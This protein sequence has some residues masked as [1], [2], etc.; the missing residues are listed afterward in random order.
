MIKR[1]A[2]FFNRIG[3]VERI[4]IGLFIGTLLGIFTPEAKFI[5]LFGTFFINALK[6]VAPI[7][8]FLWF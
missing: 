7:L 1:I 2:S 6:A 5:A 3:L 4:I 8:V